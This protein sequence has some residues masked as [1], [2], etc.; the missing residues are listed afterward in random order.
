MSKMKPEA[1]S[2][3]DRDV[4]RERERQARARAHLTEDKHVSRS[5][6]PI[7]GEPIKV[8]PP[9]EDETSRR[10]KRTLGDFNQVQPLLTKDPTHL[11]GISKAVSNTNNTG[12]S[13]NGNGSIVTTNS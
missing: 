2:D 13:Q 7:F 3:V 4:L 8:F 11:I 10:I 5:P 6:R 12:C 1:N 9:V